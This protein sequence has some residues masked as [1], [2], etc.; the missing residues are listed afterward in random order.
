MSLR[1]YAK[2][3]FCLCFEVH[4][5]VLFQGHTFE[6]L[7]KKRYGIFPWKFQ[8]GL[9]TLEAVSSKIDLCENPVE[10]LKESKKI[11]NTDCLV[12]KKKYWFGKKKKKKKNNVSQGNFEKFGLL[13]M[14]Q[15]A[16]KSYPKN[17]VWEQKPRNRVHFSFK[18]SKTVNVTESRT[19]P[20]REDNI[21]VILLLRALQTIYCYDR[22]SVTYLLRTCEI[23][24]EKHTGKSLR[25]CRRK[26]LRVSKPYNGECR[27][28]SDY[29]WHSH[30]LSLY[31]VSF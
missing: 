6:K 19:L 16:L 9:W 10:E 18:N 21:V 23:I 7:A 15:I 22:L 30:S 26:T 14:Y 8:N 4:I 28:I 27:S 17:I 12:E 3:K 24:F 1:F 5:P 20:N 11:S 2:S 29:M 25:E 31:A 13:F